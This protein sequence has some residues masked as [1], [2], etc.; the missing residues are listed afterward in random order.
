[1]SDQF[2]KAENDAFDLGVKDGETHGWN[3]LNP[4]ASDTHPDEWDAWETGV[5]VGI[6]NHEAQADL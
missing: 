2:T 1:M 6:L 5:T 4:F 3:A